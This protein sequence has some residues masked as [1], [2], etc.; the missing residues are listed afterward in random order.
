MA[1]EYK[2]IPLNFHKIASYIICDKTRMM[3]EVVLAKRCYF[4]DTCSFRFHANLSNPQALFSY[5]Q[6][7]AGIIIITRCILME[8][9]SKDGIL[10]QSYITF[11]EK[12]HASG[13]K[14]FLVEEEDLADI[15]SMCFTTIEIVNRYLLYAV[16]TVRLANGTVTDTLNADSSLKNDVLIKGASQDSTLYDRFFQAV[17]KNK[18]AEDN[19]GEELL[20]ICVHILANIPENYEHKYVILTDDKG[21]VGG[22]KKARKNS[23]DQLKRMMFTAHT[24]P[25]LAQCLYEDGFVTTA[26]EVEEFLAVCAHENEIHFLGAEEYDLEVREKKMTCS[27]LANKIVIPNAI[28]ISC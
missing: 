1:S 11:L 12:M 15:M 24:T 28:Y 6:K 27:E 2:E 26:S 19:L 25:R 3:Q 17:R 23:F 18:K 14:I 22:I 7:E 21:A 9:G 4:Y 8:L 10:R 5:L 16:R 13:I 20:T